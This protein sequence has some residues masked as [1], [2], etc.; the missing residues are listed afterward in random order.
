MG[1]TGRAETELVWATQVA[2][3][4][5]PLPL[6]EGTRPVSARFTSYRFVQKLARKWG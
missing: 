3:E 5:A 1:M 2:E 6:S 4:Q